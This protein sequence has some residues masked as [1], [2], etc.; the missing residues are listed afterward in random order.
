MKTSSK[1]VLSSEVTQEIIKV[2][3]SEVKVYRKLKSDMVKSM[4]V[5]TYKELT[6][7]LYAEFFI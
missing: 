7:K 5:F 2:I 1:L 3:E 4:F 6:V